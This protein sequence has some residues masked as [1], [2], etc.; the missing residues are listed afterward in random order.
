MVST[1][2]PEDNRKYVK[3]LIETAGPEGFI[4]CPGCD[5]PINAKPENIEAM[6][7]AGQEFGNYS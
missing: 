4:L 5:A 3:E 7:S 1:G 6:I 2:T